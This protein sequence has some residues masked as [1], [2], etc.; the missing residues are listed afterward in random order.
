MA[1][2]IHMQVLKKRQGSLTERK[3]KKGIIGRWRGKSKGPEV[4]K[5]GSYLPRGSRVLRLGSWGALGIEWKSGL[6]KSM[7]G[8]GCCLEG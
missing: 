8:L 5:P 1:D 2:I 3:G 7:E 4:G 6:G